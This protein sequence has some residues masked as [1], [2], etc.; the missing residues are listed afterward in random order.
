M[1][2]WAAAVETQG[3]SHRAVLRLSRA[4]RFP[5]YLKSIEM[6]GNLKRIVEE[7]VARVKAKPKFNVWNYWAMRLTEVG[8]KYELRRQRRA[9]EAKARAKADKKATPIKPKAKS[10]SIMS[11][12][13]LRMKISKEWELLVTGWKLMDANNDNMISRDE[14]EEGLNRTGFS[15]IDEKTRERIWQEVDIDGN[16]SVDYQEFRNGF[17]SLIKAREHKQIMDL[18]GQI[19]KEWNLL[20]TGWRLMDSNNDSMISRE[21]F[22]EGLDRTGFEWV[23]E[24]TRKKLWKEVD[25]DKNGVVDYQEF[26]KA[27]EGLIKDRP[28]RSSKERARASKRSRARVKQ[29]RAE[30]A[31]KVDNATDLYDEA[32]E[33]RYSF[34]ENLGHKNEARH[35]TSKMM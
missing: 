23:D 29:R 33:Q 5:K 34:L 22:E 25:K 19:S 26:R 20:V 14:F 15:W 8:N 21:E 13:E 2:S 31:S 18:R 4:P 12:T 35:G 24:K 28:R 1:F 6:T 3:S 30:H 27:F 16:G 7:M 17:E 32:L 10:S 9:E 11:N